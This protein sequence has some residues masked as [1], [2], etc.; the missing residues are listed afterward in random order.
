MGG[1]SVMFWNLK[2]NDNR[3][4]IE[5][6]LKEKQ[7][8]VVGFCE[9]IGN[10]KALEDLMSDNGYSCTNHDSGKCS[11]YVLK[12]ISY[13]FLG[14]SSD[15]RYHTVSINFSGKKVNIIFLHLRDNIWNDFF[16]KLN[17]SM[18][19][20]TYRKSLNR[21]V[22]LIVTGDFNLNPFSDIFTYKNA[23][24][25]L[26]S[27]HEAKRNDTLYNPIWNYLGDFDFKLKEHKKSIAPYFYRKSSSRYKSWHFFDQVLISHDLA[28]KFEYDAFSIITTIG[29][30]NLSTKRI[31]KPDAE[32]H[33]DHFPILFKFKDI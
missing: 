24:S 31:G 25:A 3:F 13:D 28:D 21:N 16:D 1:L 32:K 6:L 26:G 30:I 7:P 22:P 23:L 17:E 9:Y 4:T 15:S 33:S 27:Y 11:S 2:R 20:E 14:K 29:D 18:E 10:R 12:N 19:I 5:K 8:A